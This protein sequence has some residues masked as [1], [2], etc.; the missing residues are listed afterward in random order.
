MM[1]VS[2]TSSTAWLAHRWHVMGFT[3]AAL[4]GAS[5]LTPKTLHK[6]VRG[7]EPGH[8]A[9]YALML[10]LAYGR[11]VADALLDGRVDPDALDA[12]AAPTDA[13]SRVEIIPPAYRPRALFFRRVGAGLE[14]WVR[15]G[16]FVACAAGPH[17]DGALAL[18]EFVLRG[19][20]AVRFARRR[21]DV[22][23]LRTGP[24]AAEPAT[25]VLASR[26]R[27]VSRLLFEV[28]RVAPLLAL[29]GIFCS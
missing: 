18:V 11:D 29:G 28:R 4:A 27:R 26:V 14:P 6:I 22:W 20:L 17:E 10:P 15:R 3:V 9:V 23:E 2:R 19:Q 12:M 25:E 7:I 5:G 8:V 13:L 21:D 16:S 24:G 1:A